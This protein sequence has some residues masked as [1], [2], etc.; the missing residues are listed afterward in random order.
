[1]LTS[2]LSALIAVAIVIGV[3]LIGTYLGHRLTIDYLKIREDL[4]ESWPNYHEEHDSYAV[5]SCEYCEAPAMTLKC[6]VK[7]EVYMLCEG[8]Q[9]MLNAKPC[10]E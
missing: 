7:Q 10:A 5:T 8:C 1:M 3:F 4:P 2:I 6:S 9:T